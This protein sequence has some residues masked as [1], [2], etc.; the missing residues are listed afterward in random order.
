MIFGAIVAGGIG[1]RMNLS[2]LPK[3]F[4]PLGNEEKPIII[5]TIEK[6]MMCDRLD[7]ICLGIHKDWI[8]YM[9]D[10]LDKYKLDKE[11]FLISAGGADRNKTILNIIENIEKNYGPSE[12]HIIVTHD[13]VRP[14][15]TLRM[16]NENIDAAIEI[17]ACDTVIPCIDTI[18]AS[19]DGNLISA[20]PNRQAL[21][22]GQTPQSFKM[23]ELKNLYNDLTEAEK[24]ILTDACR[25]FVMREKPVKLVRGDTFNIKITDVSNYKIA[26]AIL[27]GDM[28]D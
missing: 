27:G 21:Y 7:R 6:F 13:A 20:I 9:E 1:T 18:V 24:D 26:S 11:K 5:H 15:L 16:I 4:L 25:I 19:E 3:Q 17:G 28:L 22:S 8:S 12:D 14:F 2:D 10:M 23:T